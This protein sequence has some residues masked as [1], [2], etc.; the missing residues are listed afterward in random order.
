M[1]DDVVNH[2][3]HYTRHP[4]GVECITITEHFNFNLGNA[5]KYV[6]RSAEKLNGGNEIEDLE[7]ARWYL[8]REIQRL[9]Q[10]NISPV[11]GQYG[12]PAYVQVSEAYKAIDAAE[13]YVTNQPPPCH[14]GQYK[15]CTCEWDAVPDAE[16]LK[17][18]R[19][20]VAMNIALEQEAER[21][22]GIARGD[23]FPEG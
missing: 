3:K 18:A 8:D 17:A 23:Q 9:R 13:R 1:T 19:R 20:R 22:V 2:P 6:W 21:D 11:E 10:P 12:K 7:K 15:D 4:S 16:L 5:I 14:C